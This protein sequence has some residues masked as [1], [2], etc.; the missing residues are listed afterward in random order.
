MPRV[1]VL[2]SGPLG[3]VTNPTASPDNDL[4]NRWLED[5]VASATTVVIPEIADYEVR[6]ELLRIRA[7]KSIERLDALKLML[8]YVPLTTATLLQAA[9]FWAQIRNQGIPTADDKALDGDVIL[10]AQAVLLSNPGDQVIVA[11]TNPKHLARLVDAR[12]WPDIQ[13]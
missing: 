1:V 6:R 2:D 12:D 3:R 13:P 9:A 4:C 8:H 11:T 10:A 5:L 7:T